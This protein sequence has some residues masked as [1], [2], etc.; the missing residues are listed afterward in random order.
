MPIVKIENPFTKEIEQVE[1]AGDD[2]T[3]QELDTLFQLFQSEQPTV[4]DVDLATAS[5]EEIQDYARQSR[6]A[7]IDPVTKKQLTEEEYVSKYKEPGVDYS[8]GLDSIGGFSRF[9]FGRMDTK[10]EKENYLES[11]VG[12]DGFRSDA[13]GRLILTKKVWR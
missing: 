13:L 12:K 4:G 2:P 7:G 6:L 3:Q 9:Q 8:T 1:I 5:V 11:V 10:E